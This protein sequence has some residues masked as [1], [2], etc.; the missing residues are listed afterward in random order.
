MNTHRIA[1]L[2]LAAAGLCHAQPATTPLPHPPAREHY[3]D[4]PGAPLPGGGYRG[5]AQVGQVNVDAQGRNVL[6]DAANE[7]SIAVDP[8]APNRMVIAWR[9]FDSVASNFRQAG[10]AW[11]N[12][13]GRTWHA[14]V[15]TPGQF[16]TDPVVRATADGV[17]VWDMLASDAAE[18]FFRCFAYRSVDAGRTWTG[19]V[20]SYGGDKE[21][22]TIDRT[23]GIGR[24]NVYTI[25][26]SYYSDFSPNNFSRSINAGQSFQAPTQISYNAWGTTAVGPS[27]EL[28]TASSGV[29]IARSTNAQDPGATPTF[30][31]VRSLN[32]GGMLIDSGSGPNPGGGTGQVWIQIDNGN[33]P[34]RGW[35]YVLVSAQFTPGDPL[36]VVFC[37]SADAGQTWSTPRKINPEPVAPNSWQWFGTMSV[38]PNGRLDVVYNDTSQSQN[39]HL[40]R[41]VYMSSSDGGDTW[42]TPQALTPQWDSYIG[43]PNQEKIGD[44]YDME[45][46]NLGA[47]LAFAATL[48]AEQD[49]YYRRIGPHD[50]NRNGIADDAEIAAGSVPDCNGNDIP[51]SCEIAANPDL[52]R[53]HNGRLDWCEGACDADFNHDGDTGTD[54]DI[55]AFFACLA[56]NC[57]AICG[58]A[59]FNADGDVGTDADI[60][61]FFRVLAGGNC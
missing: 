50:C 35:I 47:D 16:R 46:D 61:S 41:T 56:G 54:A 17:F 48:N 12:D 6:G 55:E 43:W 2:G 60:E 31:F 51:D 9:Q 29:S 20:N 26:T 37:R 52:D 21:W 53:N 38:A 22:M 39:V 13:G 18:S 32:M 25:W 49:V 4:A 11:T 42:S 14:S 3:G 24:S 8:T 23:T 57:C 27:G 34:R 15:A 5:R 33:G 28:Y 58:S 44:Y 45:S 40:C 59:D 30:A 36:D 10:Y 1:V 7:P 19:G